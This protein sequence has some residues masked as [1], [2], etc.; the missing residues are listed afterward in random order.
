MQLR[1]CLKP[2]AQASRASAAALTSR[3]DAD[4]Y[5]A[6]YKQDGSLG[7]DYFVYPFRAGLIQAT[8]ATADPLDPDCLGPA[9]VYQIATF[10][11][12]VRPAWS[13]LGPCQVPA[14]SGCWLAA[15]QQRPLHLLAG[16]SAKPVSSWS[17]HSCCA[18][19]R[20]SVPSAL[21]SQHSCAQA[22]LLWLVCW[23]RTHSS[24]AVLQLRLGLADQAGTITIPRSGG[25]GTVGV[26]IDKLAREIATRAPSAYRQQ[27]RRLMA[28]SSYVSAKASLAARDDPI[29][30]AS[31]AVAR[32]PGVHSPAPVHLCSSAAKATTVGRPL[33]RAAQTPRV[34]R[35]QGKATLC[36]PTTHTGGARR[37][38]VPA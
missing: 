13:L 29:C 17:D 31:S 22:A 14:R 26:A 18:L 8:G 6:S 2:A 1:C 19:S 12:L 33:C 11:T 21:F 5:R 4:R 38:L 23:P 3:P 36:V 16:P 9:S 15:G 7:D 24:A 25:K 30:L 10:E 35:L 27:V 20:L 37:A 34:R 32:R 28:C